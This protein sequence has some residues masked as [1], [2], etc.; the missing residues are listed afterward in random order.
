MIEL[1]RA[2][3]PLPNAKSEFNLPKFEEK[4]LQNGSRVIF[5]QKLGLPITTITF[6]VEAGS[7]YDPAGGEGLAQ[8]TAALLDEGAGEFDS[9]ALSALLESKGL[10]LRVFANNDYFEVNISGLSENID[11]MLKIVSDVV[12]DPHFRMEDF[13]RERDKI[14]NRIQQMKNQPEAMAW[15]LLDKIIQGRPNCYTFTSANE[16][17]IE[18]ITLSDVTFFHAEQIEPLKPVFTVVTDLPYNQVETAI[19]KH[20][21]GKMGAHEPEKP[22]TGFALKDLR[23]FILDRKGAP[24]TEILGGFP[25]ESLRSSR[26]DE[27]FKLVNNLYGGHF[28]SRLM[29][30]LREEKGYT[31]GVGSFLISMKDSSKFIIS[32]SVDTVNTGN[33]LLEILKEMNDVRKNIS[34]EELEFSRSQRVRGIPFMFETYD[35]ISSLLRTIVELQLPLDYFENSRQE[36]TRVTMEDAISAANHYLKLE[37]LQ[38]VLVGDREGILKTIPQ[39]L[40]RGVVEI[41][42]RGKVI[43]RDAG[44]NL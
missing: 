40:L 5:H 9:L 1:N 20:F 16:E 31:Y 10:T 15:E 41:N 26:E 27:A 19:H 39:P 11:L 3:P 18:E 2:Q 25:T 4:F 7:K 24:Q 29:R 21:L 8:L 17:S 33:A 6:I 43:R 22:D 37:N 28:N 44:G 38:F 35:M 30:N 13:E 14:R 34:D 36:L 23:F 12:Y 32:A 42:D